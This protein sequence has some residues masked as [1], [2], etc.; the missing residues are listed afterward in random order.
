MKKNTFIKVAPLSLTG[1]IVGCSNLH[2]EDY[3]QI[4]KDSEDTY[5]N[6]KDE[7]SSM[8]SDIKS[9]VVY[10]DFF[11][12]VNPIKVVKTNDS[13]LPIEY[14]RDID[15]FSN[16]ELTEREFA[17]IMLSDYGISIQFSR[18]KIEDEDED[19]E[20]DEVALEGMYQPSYGID[21]EKSREELIKEALGEFYGDTSSSN[22]ALMGI[23]KKEDKEEV[24]I[25]KIDFNG[26][27]YDFFDL[28]ATDI[29]LSWRYDSTNNEFIFYDLDTRIFYLID[30]SSEFENELTIDTSTS[31][32]SSG[33][34]SSSTS[35]SSQK[36]SLKNKS[37]HWEDLEKTLSQMLSK[38]GSI[39]FDQKNGRVIV[40][41]S[42]QVLNKIDEITTKLNESNGTVVML[43]VKHVKV[44]VNSESEYGI[45]FFTE[46]GAGKAI[47]SAIKISGGTGVAVGGLNN[48][49][50]MD[51]TNAGATAMIGALASSGA[52]VATF[53]IPFTTMNNTPFPYQSVV[54]EKYISEVQREVDDN[55]TTTNTA[56]TE[57]NRTG[58]TSVITPRVFKDNVI[59][60]G[61]INI[62][63]DLGMSEKPEF[64]NIMLPKNS[65]GSHPIKSMIPN[66]VTRVVSVQERT[67]AMKS[68]SGPIGADSFI[69]G[70]NE[71][72]HKEKEISMVI[73]TPYIF[74]NR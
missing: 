66:G 16:S 57:T 44:T 24:L 70:G 40:T 29:D 69:L 72:T 20:E 49:L 38:Y 65:A 36:V 6:I 43:D 46:E 47:S 50:Q 22:Y 4:S 28:V 62:V 34:S 63:D 13:K 67:K 19:D 2:T 8:V 39:S 35:G 21:D 26:K 53:N 55:G 14:Q 27:L 25:S 32:S 71:K 48:L 30:N 11:I 31:T 23:E 18:L 5:L 33:D 51:F 73:V 61:T 74:K 42:K 52:S 12:D 7:K 56:T 41:D 17:K 58:I 59:V 10:D 37:E 54:E 45:N 1:L 60:D 15:F 64:N 3:K 9:G 68:G